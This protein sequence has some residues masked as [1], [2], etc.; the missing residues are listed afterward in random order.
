MEKKA[1]FLVKRSQDKQYMFNLVAPNGEVI[2]TSETYTQK[3]NCYMG[4]AS[5]RANAKR[6]N[7]EGR[8]SKDSKFYFVLKATNGAVILT[9]EMY[10][11]KYNRGQG[12]AAVKHYAETADI[13][14][15]ILNKPKSAKNETV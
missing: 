6:D 8:T 15:R 4:I 2:G 14:E 9:S 11:T 3:H 13:I 5:V 12:S 7:F 1:H 10:E